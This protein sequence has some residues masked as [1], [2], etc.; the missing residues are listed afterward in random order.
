[1]NT[2]GKIKK[3]IKSVTPYGLVK[4]AKIN[5]DAGF[6]DES[7]SYPGIYN[8]DGELMRWYYLSDTSCVHTPYNLVAGRTPKHIIWDRFNRGLD[9]HFYVHDNMKETSKLCKKKYGLLR[10][11][12]SIIPNTYEWVLRESGIIKE[13]DGVYTFSERVL[14]KYENAHFAIANGSW[15]GRGRSYE[16]IEKELLDA[17]TKNIS[18]VASNKCMC[19]MHRVRLSIAQTAK[20]GGLVDVYGKSVGMYL[21]NKDDALTSYRYSIAI[22]N[23]IQPFY[24]TEKVLDCFAAKTVPIYMGATKLSKWFNMDGV[25]VISP[26]DIDRLPDILKNLGKE[27]YEERKEAIEDNFVRVRQFEC[28]EDYLSKEY[29]F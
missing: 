15:Y 21:P 26:S 28:I 9:T 6:T 18:M 29:G 2:K 1:L 8:A 24:F 23:D 22:E 16:E 20:S 19:D 25:I 12:E 10:E 17:K 5:P 3:I 11:S 7:V 13:F 27:D 14:D 4:P